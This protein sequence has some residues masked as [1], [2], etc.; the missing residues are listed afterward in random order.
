MEERSKKILI[1]LV[2]VVAFVAV[3]VFYLNSGGVEKEAVSP[4]DNITVEDN[5]TE[6]TEAINPLAVKNVTGKL[7]AV[8]IG[9]V[10]ATTESGEEISLKISQEKGASFY[11]QTKEKEDTFFNAEIGL[12]D[13]PLNKD[14]QIQYDGETNELMMVIVAE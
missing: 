11:K 14:V 10:K 5:K 8:D 6:I 2:V 7:T 13:L 9:E 3:L 12:F 4:A 1:I